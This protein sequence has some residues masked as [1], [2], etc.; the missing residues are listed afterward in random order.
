MSE[1]IK[2]GSVVER[3]ME[4]IM[5]PTSKER[6]EAIEIAEKLLN[7]PNLFY[8][9][10]MPKKCKQALQTLISIAKQ[11]EA[12]PLT[13]S[14]FRCIMCEFKPTIAEDSGQPEWSNKE[15]DEAWD[16][17]TAKK[18]CILTHGK[19]QE[20]GWEELAK[21]VFNFQKRNSA[22]LPTRNAGTQWDICH[23]FE[24]KEA[25]QEAQALKDKF[26]ITR[27]S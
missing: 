20:V 10:T 19:Q 7:V 3:V 23:D 5:K 13:K 4:V 2:I 11:Q 21:E 16:F 15:L 26:I 9:V 25:R 27:R 14:E 24:K 8:G 18:R 22:I 6:E 1:P 12:R 17:L